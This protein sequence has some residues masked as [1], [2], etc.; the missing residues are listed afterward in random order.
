MAGTH[1]NITFTPQPLK[2]GWE[3]HIEA[4]LPNGQKEHITG[5]PTEQVAKDWLADP[6]MTQQWLRKRGYAD[7]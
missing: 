6:A 7:K 4:I 2:V 3:W 1:S 5:F